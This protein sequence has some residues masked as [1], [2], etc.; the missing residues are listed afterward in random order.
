MDAETQQIPT[1]EESVADKFLSRPIIFEIIKAVIH[2]IGKERKTDAKIVGAL[3]AKDVNKILAPKRT[4]AIFINNS[5]L[6]EFLNHVG[7]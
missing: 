2:T 5:P 1:P 4:I 6:A 7:I 3:V